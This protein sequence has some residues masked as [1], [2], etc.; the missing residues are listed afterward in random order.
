MWYLEKDKTKQ[1]N[2]KWSNNTLI[3]SYTIHILL[4]KVINMFIFEGISVNIY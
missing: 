4:I 2:N 1:N 3:E